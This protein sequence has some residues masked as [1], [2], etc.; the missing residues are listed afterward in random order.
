MKFLFQQCRFSLSKFFTSSL[1]RIFSITDLFGL[2]FLQYQLQVGQGPF[3][4][5]L[6]NTR[7]VCLSPLVPAD[8]PTIPMVFFAMVKRFLI[9][10]LPQL[11]GVSMGGLPT[12]I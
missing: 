3:G 11:V 12:L 4:V 10:L 7:P 8:P 5:G 9:S 1:G 6:H 2:F